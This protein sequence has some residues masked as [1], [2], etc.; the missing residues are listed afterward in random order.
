MVFLLK[1]LPFYLISLCVSCRPC[2]CL[3]KYIWALPTV[4]I[5]NCSADQRLREVSGE[6]QRETSQLG[7]GGDAAAWP[8]LARSVA[9]TAGSCSL[10]T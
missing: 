2:S 10:M 1:E 4:L 8:G 7:L 6:H 3:Q 9:G 5:C